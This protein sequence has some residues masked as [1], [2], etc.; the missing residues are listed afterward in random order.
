MTRPIPPVLPDVSES[1]LLQVA[2]SCFYGVQKL[3]ETPNSHMLI[4]S[5]ILAA[6]GIEA[7]FKSHLLQKGRPQRDLRRIGHDLLK[8]WVAVE[9]ADSFVTGDAPNWL[10]HLNWGHAS[11]HPYR[12]LPDKH[13][14]GVPRLEDFIPWWDI[15][16]RA[17]QRS[18]TSL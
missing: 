14:V 1:S 9:A 7:T 13:G 2:W 16:L 5:G 15:K 10:R 6:Q 3:Q 17:L 11:P 4:A 12:Y 8:A 18:S